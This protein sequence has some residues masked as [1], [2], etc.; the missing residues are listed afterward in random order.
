M[1]SSIHDR[2]LQNNKKKK[3]QAGAH[4]VWR[5]IGQLA[6]VNSIPARL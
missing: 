6:V 1:Y 2:G 3:A 5:M 4:V